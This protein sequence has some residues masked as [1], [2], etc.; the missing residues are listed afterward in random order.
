[1]PIGL[2]G[3][4]IF[5]LLILSELLKSKSSTYGALGISATVLLSFFF[6]GRVMVGAAVLN[7]TL[8]ERHSRSRDQ[9]A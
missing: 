7:A 2:I 4:E 9:R 6:V 8:Y 5:N 1:M 3:V